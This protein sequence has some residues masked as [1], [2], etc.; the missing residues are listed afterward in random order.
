MVKLSFETQHRNKLFFLSL[1]SA[2]VCLSRIAFWDALQCVAFNFPFFLKLQY[3]FA[4][5]Y[6]D[7]H[8]FTSL[9]IC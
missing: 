7:D 4:F 1:G 6:D 8:S 9:L 2:L 3:V 5:S